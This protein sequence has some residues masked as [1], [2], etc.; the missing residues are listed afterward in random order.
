MKTVNVLTV[1]DVINR[2]K[3]QKKP[4]KQYS[5]QASFSEAEQNSHEKYQERKFGPRIFMKTETIQTIT[6]TKNS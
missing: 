2:K 5:R 6:P 3:K 1:S 4:K